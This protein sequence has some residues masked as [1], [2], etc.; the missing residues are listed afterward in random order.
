MGFYVDS[1]EYGKTCR[2]SQL[3]LNSEMIVEMTTISVINWKKIFY[4]LFQHSSFVADVRF[5]ILEDVMLNVN[6]SGLHIK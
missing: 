1:S 4:H 6:R 2:H 3:S 5:A